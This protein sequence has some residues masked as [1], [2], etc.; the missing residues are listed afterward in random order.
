MLRIPG[1]QNCRLLIERS[2]VRV[3]EGSREDDDLPVVLQEFQIALDKESRARLEH[4]LSL[5]ESTDIPGAVFPIA[6]VQVDRGV[7]VVSPRLEGTTLDQLTDDGEAIAIG[8]FINVA[9]EVTGILG[10]M[11]Q[12]GIQHR[13]LRPTNILVPIADKSGGLRIVDP[14]LSVLFHNAMRSLWSPHVI[15][16]VL[17]YVA[18]EQTGRLGRDA[19]HRSDL[20]SL[21]V[22][23]YELLSGKRPFQ[24]QDPLALI[25]AHIALEAEPLTSARPDIGESLSGIVMKLLE[26]DPEQRYQSAAG[27]IADLERCRDELASHGAVSTFRPGQN[28]LVEI[29]QVSGRLYG[30]ESDKEI[31]EEALEQACSGRPNLL[32]LSGPPGIGKSALAGWVARSAHLRNCHFLTGKCQQYHRDRPYLPFSQAFTAL[33]EQLLLESDESLES[34]KLDFARSIGALGRIIVDLCPELSRIV[35]P[36]LELPVLPPQESQTRANLALKRFI[37]MLAAAAHPLVLFFDDLHWADRASLDFLEE[38]FSERS[39]R[40]LLVVGT[41][42]DTEVHEDHPVAMV[43]EAIGK[44][45]VPI[46]K[47]ALPLLEAHHIR[48]LLVDS[49]LCTAADAETPAQLIHSKTL[50]NPFFVL[51]FIRS[52]YTSGFVQRVPER[53]WVWDLEAIRNRH[54]TDNV[55]D[56]VCD[57]L[58]HMPEPTR[59]VLN[60]AAIAGSHID[61]EMLALLSGRDLT[62]ILRALEP[63]FRAELI[64]ETDGRIAFVHDRVQEAAC[65][66][67][68]EKELPSWHLNVGRMLLAH[69]DEKQQ[70]ERIFEIVEHFNAAI[71]EIPENEKA[72]AAELNVV[73]LLKAKRSAAF[74]TALDFAEHAIQ[75]LGPEAW[76][77]KYELSFRLQQ[78]RVELKFLTGDFTGAEEGAKQL[79]SIAA[80]P[81]DRAKAGSL[82]LQQY[83]MQ[84]R[85]SEAIDVAREALALVAVNLPVENLEMRFEEEL[86]RSKL[87]LEKRPLSSLL[88]APL[89]ADSG[90]SVALEILAL[91]APAIFVSRPELFK[92]SSILMTNISLE[93]GHTTFS[94][95]AYAVYGFILAMDRGE[96]RL[97]YDFGEI[98]MRLADQFGDP[99][100]QCRTTH[101]AGFIQHYVAHIRET[102]HLFK[103]GFKAG[104]ECGEIEWS[105][106][107]AHFRAAR[108]AIEGTPLSEAQSELERLR[109]FTDRAGNLHAVH[110][111]DAVRFPIAFLSEPSD[112]T[113]I[114]CGSL[115]EAEQLH[116]WEMK[117]S[118]FAIFI[119]RVLKS[120]VR[121][122][123][124]HYEEALTEAERSIELSVYAP[125]HIYV[126]VAHF[127][128]GMSLLA[129]SHSTE[130]QNKAGHIARAEEELDRMSF[131]AEGCPDNYLDKRILLEAELARAK[132]DDGTTWRLYDDAC[133]QARKTGFVQ[134]GALACELAMRFWLDR[135]KEEFAAPYFERA[136]EGYRR[137]GAAKKN[138]RTEGR[139]R[140]RDRDGFY[141]ERK[142]ARRHR[143]PLGIQG[144][145]GYFPGNRAALT[146]QEIDEGDLGKRGRT[147]RR[148]SPLPAGK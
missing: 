130:G 36:Q 126:E 46:R 16:Q 125:N 134:Q 94:C 21:G 86:A 122:L 11:H 84:A 81:V 68:G 89:M 133:Q 69:F 129:V 10:K 83:N 53:G 57:R 26:K 131:L 107:H 49:L 39:E 108:L 33:T 20:Y 141:K 109:D 38:L 74:V 128:K 105:C 34:W 90:K 58:A 47:G 100:Q 111:I 88:D 61:L 114:S 70:D 142:P 98:G 27:L 104:V 103:K 25:H 64:R 113:E 135:G 52:L 12:A 60:Y 3:F 78:E 62:G 140:K 7:V 144:D 123:L 146:H 50:G 82:L 22:I 118:F 51:T 101:M 42:R 148:P 14:G 24:E 45:G 124:G 147:A 136:I 65:S 85:Y 71:E 137:W 79:L 17:P 1:Y 8:T 29:L 117:E 97:A 5:F 43:V 59:K 145:A 102:N 32:L 87:L 15:Q 139:A 40:C 96:Y 75:L 55:V 143:F 56:L 72:R 91:V 76:K 19:D 66:L 13:N 92:I 121:Y 54:V 63:A 37:S 67:I 6:T 28:D 95:Y 120:Y 18:P 23:F 115:S 31:L 93:Y 106:I 138:R 127:L 73:A 77:R 132:G 9:L 35:G 41:Y 4:E 99:I 44:Q 110:L 119:Y 112:R 80:G 116:L 30:R 2:P 48:E